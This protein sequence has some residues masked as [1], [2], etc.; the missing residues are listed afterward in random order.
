MRDVMKNLSSGK[1]DKKCFAYNFVD[2]VC[3][4]QSFTVETDTNLSNFGERIILQ[5]HD[6]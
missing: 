2:L 4:L 3:L 1:N 5:I 6:I